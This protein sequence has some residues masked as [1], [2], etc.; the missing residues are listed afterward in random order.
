MLLL[1][2]K[3]FFRPSRLHKPRDSH[4]DPADDRTD[5]TT[6]NRPPQTPSER[7]PRPD[8]E[9]PNRLSQVFWELAAKLQPSLPRTSNWLNLTDVQDIEEPP[10]DGGRFADV[11]RGRLEGRAVAIKSYRCYVRFDCELVRMVSQ[12]KH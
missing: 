7:H 5:L 9:N 1:W 3:N 10:V 2:L 8:A 6:T 4:A 11:W 12:N